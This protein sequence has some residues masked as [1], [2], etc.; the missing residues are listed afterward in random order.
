MRFVRLT[1]E[2][3]PRI[4]ASALTTLPEFCPGDD[5]PAAIVAAAERE[6]LAWG[7]GDVLVIAQKVVSK[8]EGKIIDLRG[9][10][11]SPQAKSFADEH[12][13]DPRLVELV[14]R[15]SRRIVRME[16]GVLIAETQ[17][18]FICANAGVDQSNVPSPGHAT[19][20]PDDPDRSACAIRDRL[21]E[22]TGRNCGVIISDSF[23][24]PWRLGL[25]NVAI[26]IAGLP[27]LD[28]SRGAAD[29][30]GRLL[31]ATVSATADELAAAAGL[32]MRKENGRPV[33][34]VQGLRLA[35]GEG[36]ARDLIRPPD[37]DLFR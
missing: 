20:L 32:L 13:K 22:A 24:R 15:Q 9:I 30:H 16:R 33:V 3:A 21:R 19:T 34:F 10:A 25:V 5:L 8:V 18:G 27:A 36:C 12:G 4:S 17:H 14:L 11:P 37:D 29:R 23:G 31:H 7:E 6:G 26:G 28:D 1:M 2:T 35:A